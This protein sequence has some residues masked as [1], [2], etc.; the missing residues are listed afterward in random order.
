MIEKKKSIIQTEEAEKEAKKPLSNEELSSLIKASNNSKFNETELKV[1]KNENESFKKITLHDIA[2]QINKQN[3]EKAFEAE[4]KNNLNRPNTNQED[5]NNVNENEDED[6]DTNKV[7]SDKK[8]NS[9]STNIDTNENLNNEE[10]KI[11]EK[12]NIDEDEHFNILEKEKQVAYEKGKTDVLNE[13]K[14]GSDAA[15]AQL[16]KI[17]ES[18]SKVEE[19][20][21]KNFEK[22]IE[23]KVV[24][25]VFD[26]T[27]KIIKEL[28]EEFLKKIKGLTSQLEN[29][30]GNIKIFISEKDFKVIENNKN[31]KNEI[32]KLS[33]N[34]DKDLKHGEIEIKVNG[35]KI[36]KT[37][38]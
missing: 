34:P 18:I 12:K 19:L 24:E 17:I 30:E 33:I 16:K 14:E 29:I 8:E 3:N 13:I 32:K 28:P 4:K 22:N 2:K 38:A 23:E 5:N 6:E 10:I 21:L 11:S 1:K 31:I 25:L 20:D 15:I 7:L 36:R 37:I 27:G 26:L 35:I 9:E